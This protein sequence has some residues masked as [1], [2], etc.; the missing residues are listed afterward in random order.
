MLLC[1]FFLIDILSDVVVNK[2]VLGCFG[3][4]DR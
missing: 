1:F 4:V 3:G 2:V